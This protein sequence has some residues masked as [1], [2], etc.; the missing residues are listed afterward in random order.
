MSKRRRENETEIILLEFR[1]GKMNREGKRVVPD[2][3][4]GL[5]TVFQL[6]DDAENAVHIEWHEREKSGSDECKTGVSAE[7]SLLVSATQASVKLMPQRVVLLSLVSPKKRFFFWMQGTD[8]DKDTAL[9]EEFQKLLRAPPQPPV[10]TSRALSSEQDQLPVLPPS[11]SSL[12]SALTP[13]SAPVSAST[14]ATSSLDLQSILQST[15][16]G[17]GITADMS[18]EEIRGPSL[19]N[20]LYDQADDIIPVLAD[21]EV[22]TELLPHLPSS[23]QNSSE[24]FATVRSPHFRAAL[25]TLN[26]ALRQ[27]QLQM[28][29]AQ[30]GVPLT[31]EAS[32][33]R[34]PV[35]ALIQ[36]IQ[37]QSDRD[38]L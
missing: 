24:L 4:P 29:L 14:P 28:L 13:A 32:A 36:S 11:T 37:A 26:A 12:S 25:R 17:M 35:V 22:R 33:T 27:G 6:T 10:S 2:T 5:L 16:S 38:A 18:A 31:P 3:R 15:L 20:I 34:N 9:I 30:L 23:M 19:T 1:A 21:E 7:I 8:V